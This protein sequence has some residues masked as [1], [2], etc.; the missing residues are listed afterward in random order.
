MN[1]SPVTWTQHFLSFKETV[2][3]TEIIFGSGANLNFRSPEKT[4]KG[5]KSAFLTHSETFK[6]HLFFFWVCHEGQS[7][8]LEGVIE[9]TRPPADLGAQ[10]GDPRRL[11]SPRPWNLHSAHLLQSRSHFQGRS[12]EQ[13]MCYTRA[14]GISDWTPLRLL[15]KL[16]RFWPWMWR[17]ALL[18]VPRTSLGCKFPASET[19]HLPIWR[20]CLFFFFSVSACPPC[21]GARFGTNALSS[22]LPPPAISSL[23]SS[24][25]NWSRTT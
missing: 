15:D 21:T 22:C 17:P 9:R 5:E 12:L 1:F 14:D 13:A 2:N 8:V 4:Q 24:L 18:S 3:L 20:G 25:R 11:T 6:C 7:S 10:P 16:L 19:C 23:G